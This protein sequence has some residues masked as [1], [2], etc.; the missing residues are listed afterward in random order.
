MF[1]AIISSDTSVTAN[2]NIPLAV[3]KNTNADVEYDAVNK[4]IKF[5]IPGH[6][7]VDFHVVA[8]DVAAGDITVSEVLNGV[9]SDVVLAASTSAATTDFITLDV[10]D[11]LSLKPTTIGSNATLSYQSDVACTATTGTLT[12][13]RIGR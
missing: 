11:I 9:T 4:L 13:I 8:T 5:N 2:T 10:P 7:Q 12:I 3:V 6:Y 1:K